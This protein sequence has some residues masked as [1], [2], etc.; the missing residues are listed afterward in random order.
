MPQE[1]VEKKSCDLAIQVSKLSIKEIAKGV[2]KYLR[3]LKQR[4]QNKIHAD[5]SIKGK[6]TVKQLLSQG[7]GVA[8]MPIGDTHLKDFEKVARKYGV[9]F[10]VVKDTTGEK[11]RYTVFFK[12]KD[13][14]AITQV[15]KEYSEKQMKRKTEERTSIR[16]VLAKFKEIADRMPRKAKEKKK[17]RSR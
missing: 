7:Q 4:K 2:D 9:D 1:E 16:E 15:L 10:A 3:Y 6:Q 11:A 14:D 12:A 17:E 8:S 5:S 13:A